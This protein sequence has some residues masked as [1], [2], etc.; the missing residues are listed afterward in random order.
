[1]KDLNKKNSNIIFYDGDCGFCNK[2]I[3]F[4]LKNEKTKDFVFVS[5]Q[6]KAAINFLK[7][8][9]N[10]LSTIIVFYNQNFYYRGEAFAI[11]TKNLKS[12]YHILSYIIQYIPTPIINFIYDSIAKI[13][14]K[15]KINSCIILSNDEKK[16][17]LN[18]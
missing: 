13:R 3:Q 18:D 10:D 2:T 9:Q 14:R 8:K 4:I 1:M 11:I 17:F 15:I 5:Q 6:S 7:E 16:R 12:P